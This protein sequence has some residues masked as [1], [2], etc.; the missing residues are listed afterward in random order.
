MVEIDGDSAGGGFLVG[1]PT[2]G[3]TGLGLG[4]SSR[5]FLASGLEGSVPITGSG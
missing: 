1:R 2:L 3:C 4:L 5:F